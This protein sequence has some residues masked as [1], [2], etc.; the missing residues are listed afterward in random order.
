MWF[1]A[2]F[3]RLTD[4]SG[5]S[6]WPGSGGLVLWGRP[7][8]R[9]TSLWNIGRRG[10]CTFVFSYYSCWF[11][12][13]TLSQICIFPLDAFNV[14]IVTRKDYGWKVGV[15]RDRWARKGNMVL[16]C[17][18]IVSTLIAIWTPRFCI[19]MKSKAAVSFLTK[20]S[21]RDLILELW[22]RRPSWVSSF[23]S[24]SRKCQHCMSM[25]GQWKTRVL[26]LQLSSPMASCRFLRHRQQHLTPV[27][28]RPRWRW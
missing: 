12:K 22:C 17:L 10:Q 28:P 24:P 1:S 15:S 23:V 25:I 16:T 9:G 4:W 26:R 11:P 27:G 20:S 7:A 13:T 6:R 21:K 14:P 19:A 5:T 3:F 8:M 18:M 2:S